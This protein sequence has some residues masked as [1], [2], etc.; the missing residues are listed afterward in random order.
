MATEVDRPRPMSTS[1]S[2]LILMIAGMLVAA[3]TAM[4]AANEHT[5]RDLDN[6]TAILSKDQ[7][8]EKCQEINCFDRSERVSAL[9]RELFRIPMDV[10]RFD[11]PAINQ[12]TY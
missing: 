2:G 12:K 1:L 11:K 9:F 7:R 6:I 8:H 5:R 3:L 4:S 10:V